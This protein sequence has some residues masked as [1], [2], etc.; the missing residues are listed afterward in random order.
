M[1]L[2][3]EEM[4]HGAQAER[5]DPQSFEL[6]GRERPREPERRRLVRLGPPGEDQRDAPVPQPPGSVLDCARCL[7]I[8]PVE[9]VDRDRDRAA[10]LQVP[11][12][13]EKGDGNRVPLRALRAAAPP[14]APAAG[15]SAAPAAPRR[16]PLRAGRR[17]R[18]RKAASPSHQA[19]RRARGSPI[20]AQRRPPPPTASSFRFRPRLRA[21]GRSVAS[22][23][24]A[25]RRRRR[26]PRPFLR[27]KPVP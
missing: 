5:P 24:R 20:A 7:R 12:R 6:L 2:G 4:V 21:A 18:R 13:I 25:K 9:V 10:A 27:S 22:R 26:V 19:C 15:G 16:G 23:C 14:R 8:E 1:E 11:K 3:L 17:A